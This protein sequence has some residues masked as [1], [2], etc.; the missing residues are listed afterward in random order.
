MI[1]ETIIIGDNAVNIKVLKL[2]S[3]TFNLLYR[4][5]KQ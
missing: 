3:I 4:L 2:S 5:S 1:A